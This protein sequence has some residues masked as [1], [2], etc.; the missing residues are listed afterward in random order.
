MVG[1]ALLV[2]VTALATAGPQLDRLDRTRGLAV[3]GPDTVKVA[4]LDAEI[5]ASLAATEGSGQLPRLDP[6]GVLRRLIQNRLLEQEGYRMKADQYSSVRNQMQEFVRLQAVNAL[7]DSVSA[8]RPGSTPEKPEDLLGKVTTT[9]RYAHILVK[10]EAQARVLR[11]SLQHGVP[12]GDLARR[13]SVDETASAGGDLGWA[14]EGAYVDRFEAAAKTLRLHEIAGPVQTEFGWHLIT[15][16]AV[17]NDT[18]NSLDMARDLL[19]AREK[20]RRSQAVGEFVKSLRDRYRV[21]VNEGLLSRLDYESADPAVQKELQS[22]DSTLAVLPG[23]KL[24]VRGLTREIHFKYFHGTGGR[25]DAAAVRDRIFQDWLTETLLSHE[26][27]IRGFDRRSEIVD[28]ARREERRLVREEV[29]GSILEYEFKPG[30]ADV[31]SYYRRHLSVFTPQ[32]RVK[33]W[34]ALLPD[35]QAAR[36]FRSKLD[37]GAGFRWLT[38]RTPAAS[39]QPAPYPADWIDPQGVGLKAGTYGEGTTIGPIALPEGWA[40]A[41]VAAVEQVKP[42]L[43]EQCRERVVR[44]MRN[45][46]NRT[47]LEQALSRLEADTGVTILD[48]ARAA[49]SERIEG[50]RA[51]TAK[52]GR[53]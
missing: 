51:S 49:V 31:E 33:L 4:D 20:G 36:M 52:G 9:R 37:G 38:D 16:N 48:G 1:K 46:R 11:D 8:L 41:Q 23:G 47:V 22:S 44:A 27:R 24:T 3:V 13:H 12:F 7:L 39:A 2:L 14:P 10:D 25:P 18:L 29:L 5:A 19:D 21:T 50:W 26:A 45:E 32:P 15:L 34:S 43:L 17:Q 28:R 42:D 6:D 53:S 35:E 30:A 40:V